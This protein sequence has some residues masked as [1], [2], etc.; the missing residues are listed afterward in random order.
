MN[1]MLQYALY[2]KAMSSLP[3][4]FV[5]NAECMSSLLESL[6][7]S[8]TAFEASEGEAFAK[9][10]AHAHTAIKVL[11]YLD[12]KTEQEPDPQVPRESQSLAHEVRSS[13]PDSSPEKVSPVAV[14]GVGFKTIDYFNLPRDVDTL[15]CDDQIDLDREIVR[16]KA[17][18]HYD[19]FKVWAFA[20][21]DLTESDW[22]FGDNDPGEDY[23]DFVDWLLESGHGRL[24]DVN[25]SQ[26]EKDRFC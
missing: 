3:L 15:F 1:V 11:T 18:P 16:A 14:A 2:T 19:D 10:A 24:A 20:K 4:H 9:R 6:Q 25:Q 23:K 12:V 26:E 17:R 8:V 7:H 5:Q 21:F 13:P 22:S